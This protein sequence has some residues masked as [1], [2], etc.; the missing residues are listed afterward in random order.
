MEIVS[1]LID[2]L[3]LDLSLFIQLGIFLLSY[4]VL[5]YLLFK[6]YNS[7]AQKRFDATTGSLESATQF[8]EEIELLKREYGK[9]VKETNEKVKGIY[10]T[11]DASAK[12]E[13]Q[14]ILIKAQE[15][16]LAEKTTRSKEIEA[17]Y[18]EESKKIPQLSQD[19]KDSLKKVLLGA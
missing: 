14:D 13:A 3:E 6:P 10:D 18:Q 1:G 4:I 17:L 5:H 12:K 8:D 15:D 7:V 2:S 9:A 19:L 11:A 16:Y